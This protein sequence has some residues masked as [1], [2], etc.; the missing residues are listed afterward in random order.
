MIR[1]FCYFVFHNVGSADT[2]KQVLVTPVLVKTDVMLTLCIFFLDP[3]GDLFIDFGDIFTDDILGKFQ[4]NLSV[5]NCCLSLVPFSN[6]R[7]FTKIKHIL[8]VIS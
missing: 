2:V 6:G 5:T 8:F 1:P 3:L 4:F 7:D